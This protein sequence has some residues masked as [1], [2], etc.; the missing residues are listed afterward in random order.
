AQGPK[1]PFQVASRFLNPRLDTLGHSRWLRLWSL[2]RRQDAKCTGD[3]ELQS[4]RLPCLARLTSLVTF[5]T[6]ASPLI[7]NQQPSPQVNNTLLAK[8]RDT[9]RTAT[10]GR[11]L[12]S[13]LTFSQCELPRQTLVIDF[14]T[15]LGSSQDVSAYLPSGSYLVLLCIDTTTHLPQQETVRLCGVS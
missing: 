3:A 10:P 1:G 15:Q 6:L 13:L 12:E 2:T 14:N 7:N 11:L 8:S 4:R 9:Q 5:T